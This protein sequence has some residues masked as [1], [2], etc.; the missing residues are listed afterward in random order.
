MIAEKLQRIRET[1]LHRRKELLSNYERRRAAGEEASTNEPRDEADESV[2]LEA[3]DEAWRQA[4]AEA[5]EVSRIDAALA[6]MREDT[7][8]ECIECGE[9]IDEKRLIALPTASRCVSCQEGREAAAMMPS[10]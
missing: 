6:R 9:E 5:R 7:F 3:Q 8:G 10:M 2:R 1:L 4:E